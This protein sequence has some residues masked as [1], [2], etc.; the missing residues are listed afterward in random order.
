[1]SRPGTFP[2]WD[3]PPDPSTST[4]A[5]VRAGLLLTLALFVFAFTPLDASIGFRLF[6]WALLAA[7]VADWIRLI[8][9]RY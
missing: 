5:V 8:V 4:G 9:R 1:M 7:A 2:G 6:T 3:D